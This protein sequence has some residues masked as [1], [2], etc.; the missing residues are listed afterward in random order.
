MDRLEF[1]EAQTLSNNISGWITEIRY[2]K[3]SREYYYLD[4]NHRIGLTAI[5][6]DT[7]ER[8]L[9]IKL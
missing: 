8:T 1:T 7:A 4:V 2:I 9:D 3:N 6:Q 5:I